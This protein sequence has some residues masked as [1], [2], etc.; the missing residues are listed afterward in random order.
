M[1]RRRSGRRFQ[2]PESMRWVRVVQNTMLALVA[3]G[4]LYLVALVMMKSR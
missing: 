3:M 1:M 2:Q 4:T